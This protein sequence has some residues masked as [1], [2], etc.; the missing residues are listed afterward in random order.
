MCVWV[1]VVSPV[2]HFSFR[3]LLSMMTRVEIHSITKE[4]MMM[5]KRTRGRRKRGVPL[6]EMRGGLARR[7]VINP[8]CGIWLSHGL[9]RRPVETEHAPADR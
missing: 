6:T 3:F 9:Q 5:S 2:I 1:G 4:M 7:V 8:R